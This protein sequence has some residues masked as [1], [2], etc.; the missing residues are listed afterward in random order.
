MAERQPSCLPACTV[1]VCVYLHLCLRNSLTYLTDALSLPVYHRPQITRLYPALSCPDV[2]IFLQLNLRHCLHFLLRVVSYF[3]CFYAKRWNILLVGIECIRCGLLRWMILMS[4]SLPVTRLNRANTAE[5]IGIPHGV[6][7][8]G[9]PRNG[10]MD[11]MWPSPNY[12]AICLAF[13]M[14]YFY[15]VSWYWY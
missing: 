10:T 2:S 11:S 6:E 5:R 14:I 8:L 9:G 3:C 12:F 7:T 13:C 1:F 4:I 15:N